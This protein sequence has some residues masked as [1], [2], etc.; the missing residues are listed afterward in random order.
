MSYIHPGHSYT[1]RG[2]VA[3][4]M[5]KE[6]EGA[7]HPEKAAAIMVRDVMIS[8]AYKSFFPDVNIFH[9][10]ILILK[11]LEILEVA[12]YSSYVIS[13]T[14]DDPYLRGISKWLVEFAS[15]F[16]VL[17]EPFEKQ[18]IMTSEDARKLYERL[19]GRVR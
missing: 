2:S 12:A 18:S 1:K 3:E 4:G 17:F 8:S 5:Y 9:R 10:V 19:E 11:E 14:E 13:S 6:W 7:P 16:R 15:A